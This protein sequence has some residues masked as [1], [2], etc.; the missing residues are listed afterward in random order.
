MLVAPR[1][2]FGPW[3]SG[4]VST[5]TGLLVY[6]G[7]ASGIC[8]AIQAA[9][10]GADVLVV[11]PSRWLGG[12]LTAAG[13]SALDGNKYGAG[14]GLV[15]EFRDQLA[16]HYGSIESLF[17]GWISLY[18]YEPHV[19][20][21]ILRGMAEPL[22]RLEI[23]YESDVV[24]YERSGDVRRVEV[25]AADGSRSQVA[26]QVFVDA[27][28]YGDGM[29]I[30]S[31][32]YRL[33][34]ESRDEFGESAAPEVADMEMQDLTYVAT[35]VEDPTSARVPESSDSEVAYRRTFRCS[36]T[37]NCPN[38]DPV[39]LNHTVHTWDSFIGYARLPNNKVLLNWPH[40]ANDFPVTEAMFEDRYYRLKHLAA[41][42][43]HTLQYIKY[44]QTELG[45]PE[46]R[47]ATDEVIQ[48]PIVQDDVVASEG[49]VRAPMVRDAIAVGDYF[50]DHHHSKHHLPPGQR[51][52]EDYPDAAPFQIPLRAL[53]PGAIDERFMVG[54]KN[55]AVT[56][57]VNGCT[58]L[59]PPV[60]LLGQAIGAVA[61]LA[62]SAGSAPTDVDVSAVQ[63]A[64]IDAGSQLY[65][66]YD[67]PADHRA[68]GAVQRL[69]LRGA[70]DETDPTALEPDATA[71]AEI[72]R[73]W[74][75]R[76]G[77][78]D[79]VRSDARG[80]LTAGDLTADFG[81]EPTDSAPLTRAEF[82]MMLDELEQ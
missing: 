24:G 5:E 26:C 40:H 64:L 67:V 54:E 43:L 28:E 8:A 38:P 77:R 11:E 36:T 19:G 71:E 17:T 39:L 56:H 58:R 51:L 68:F 2:V 12:M 52:V 65:L 25:V 3:Y 21:R 20:E 45:H 33:G 73:T 23:M 60:M 57:I 49:S 66:I 1:S 18:C 61:S 78:A 34:R 69:A 62:I 50:L 48:R 37:E 79:L 81:R 72:A 70:L 14:G 4:Q 63:T 47:I 53:L 9:R 75:G 31:I 46:W 32:P 41:A 82:L 6:G 29:A 13:V 16:E 22:S 10:M 15:K 80:N 27:T 55:I 59:Q 42:R 44:M 30:A 74:A 7:G 35:L 76:I